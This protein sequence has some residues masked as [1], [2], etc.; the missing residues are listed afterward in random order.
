[1]R[2]GFFR[3]GLAATARQGPYSQA[4]FVETA[5]PAVEGGARKA[6]T[7]WPYI[8]DWTCLSAGNFFETIVLDLFGL[9]LGLAQLTARPRLH[10][11]DAT[12]C[13][14]GLK[15]QGGLYQI[16]ARGQVTPLSS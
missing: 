14:H 9:E 8:N 16:N 15:W 11:L 2:C 10:A 13:L 12:A 5:A 6:P 4:H 3:P 7:E 1:M